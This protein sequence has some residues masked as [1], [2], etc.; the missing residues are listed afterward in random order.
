MIPPAPRAFYGVLAARSLSYARI[1]TR[2]LF[3]NAL[4]R[5]AHWDHASERKIVR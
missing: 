2:S 4:E 1:R 5:A 3:R